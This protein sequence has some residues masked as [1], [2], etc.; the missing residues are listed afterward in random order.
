MLKQSKAGTAFTFF[1]QVAGYT[2]KTWL[3]N[4]QDV[5]GG[6]WKEPVGFFCIE[7]M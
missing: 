2:G 1:V 6:V 4:Y 7:N 3:D 5:S